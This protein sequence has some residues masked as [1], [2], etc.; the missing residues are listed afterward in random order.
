MRLLP[1]VS[2]VVC[3]PSEETELCTYIFVCASPS[4]FRSVV[5]V[6]FLLKIKFGPPPSLHH[7]QV[8]SEHNIKLMRL[9]V[10]VGKLPALGIAQKL[11]LTFIV[12]LVIAT[13]NVVVVDGM[14]KEADRV[15]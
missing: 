11:G 15:A 6:F 7:C 14:L 13:I 5:S 10:L 9:P 3:V 12:L 2:L 1:C 8:M 4:T